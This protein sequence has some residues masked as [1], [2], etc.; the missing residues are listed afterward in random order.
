[1]VKLPG[2]GQCLREQCPHADAGKCWYPW[3]STG[4]TNHQGIAR[5]E[6][7]V[8]F[9]C[10][11]Q[12][13]SQKEVEVFVEV[14]NIVSNVIVEICLRL[15]DMLN[16]VWFV[17]LTRV[18]ALQSLTCW[19]GLEKRRWSWGWVWIK[20]EGDLKIWFLA[21]RFL[22]VNVNIGTMIHRSWSLALTNLLVVAAGTRPET[23]ELIKSYQGLLKVNQYLKAC[24]CLC[25]RKMQC[26][27]TLFQ[28]SDPCA[29]GRFYIVHDFCRFFCIVHGFCTSRNSSEL[30]WS[31]A[32]G[33]VSGT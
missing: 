28:S 8:I 3:C 13:F 12:W 25:N 14:S 22:Y 24:S 11:V 26:F 16:N 23:N 2:S 33:N 20:I 29:N 31:R 4:H 6:V 7:S 27:F 32:S 17:H 10:V 30:Y 18:S 15:G 1:M 19:K 5:A 9:W 21:P